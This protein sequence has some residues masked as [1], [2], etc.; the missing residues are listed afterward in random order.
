MTID[1]GIFIRNIYYMLTYAFQE[2]KQNNYEEIAGEEFDEIHDLFAEILVRGISYQLKQGLHKEYISC[3]GSLSTLKGKLDINGTINNLMRKQQKIDCEYD[4]LSENNKFNQILKTTVQFLLKHPKVKSDRKASLKR[5]MLFFS[6]VEVID[7]LTI[8]WTTMRFDRNCKTYQMLL[9]VCYFIL[10]GMLM[11]TERGTYKMRDFS[12]EHMCRLYEKFVLEYYR[13]H[14]PEL[15]AKA[16]QIDWNIDKEQS[17]SSILPIMRTDITLTFKERTLIIDTKYYSKS[18]QCQ[19]DKRTIHSNNLYQI[20]SYV[21]NYDVNH[22]G[23]VD[24]MLLYVKTEEDITPDGQTTFRD[25]NIIY[26][27]TLD[28]NQDFENIKKQLDVF[29]EHSL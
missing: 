18:M 17:T 21:M 13:K 5:L 15:K 29:L 16:T 20:H 4:E 10:D 1:K 3:H 26:Y 19:F 7:I 23:N 24:G 2:L 8:N 28:L 9:Y 14:Y 27:R 25:G 12:D 6:N 11:T 22:T